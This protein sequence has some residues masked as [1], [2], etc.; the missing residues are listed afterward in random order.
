MWPH[1]QARSNLTYILQPYFTELSVAKLTT[2]LN[3]ACTEN[4]DKSWALI[5]K[6]IK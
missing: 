6:T 5:K 2:A 3:P 1:G 4:S